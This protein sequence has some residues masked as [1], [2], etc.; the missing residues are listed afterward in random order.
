MRGNPST[1][2]FAEPGVATAEDGHVVLDGPDGVALTLTPEAALTTAQRLVEASE[3]AL[4]QRK[5][6]ASEA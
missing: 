4:R 1:E 5:G 2:P 3:E 6:K